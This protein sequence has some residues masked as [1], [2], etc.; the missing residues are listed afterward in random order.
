MTALMNPFGIFT[1]IHDGK[2]VRHTVAVFKKL[3]IAII[4]YIYRFIM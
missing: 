1:L 4:K 3:F 2:L